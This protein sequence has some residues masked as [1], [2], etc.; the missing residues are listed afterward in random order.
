MSNIDAF[1]MHGQSNDNALGNVSIKTN[2][3][4]MVSPYAYGMEKSLL[5][6]C[7]NCYCERNVCLS[8]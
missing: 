7:S 4:R 6:N 3:N 1:N 2:K 5:S 8:F